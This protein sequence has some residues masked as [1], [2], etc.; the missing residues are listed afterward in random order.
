MLLHTIHAGSKQTTRQG[1]DSTKELKQMVGDNESCGIHTQ[2]THLTFTLLAACAATAIAKAWVLVCWW[3]T[4][5]GQRILVGIA[6]AQGPGSSGM[7]EWS[8]GVLVRGAAGTVVKVQCSQ[9][10]GRKERWKLLTQQVK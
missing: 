4:R 10:W 3:E 5:R 9:I 6:L 7:W 2:L 8:Q 1:T